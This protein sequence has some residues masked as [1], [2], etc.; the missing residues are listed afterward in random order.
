MIGKIER[1]PA[2]E[3]LQI[4]RSIKEPGPQIKEDPVTE[5]PSHESST[6]T[7]NARKNEMA[8]TSST[9]KSFLNSQVA[10]LSKSKAT[11]ATK[12][13]VPIADSSS[14]QTLKL[15]DKGPEVDRL[16][17]DLQMWQSK[18]GLEV[19][20]FPK[21]G[22]YNEEIERAVRQF[23]IANNMY[24]TGKA[25]SNTQNRLKLETDPN[26]RSLDNDVKQN[27]RSSMDIYAD[28]PAA[29]NNI[30]NLATDRQFAHLLSK[31]SQS[32]A[33]SGLLMHPEDKTHLKNV[34]DAVL[35]VAILEKEKSLDH[36]PE[37]TKRQVV[38]TLFKKTEDFPTP[39]Y[40]FRSS[41]ARERIIELA[42]NPQFG[43]L[44]ASQQRSLLD[45][46]SANHGD[47][48]SS[49]TAILDSPAYKK[50]DEK[51]KAHVVD[52]TSKNAML[53]VMQNLDPAKVGS[54][55]RRLES[56][57][58]L[59]L[60]PKFLEASEEDKWAQLKPFSNGV[61]DTKPEIDIL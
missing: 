10:A 25:D 3:Y 60:N 12:D 31:D 51:M 23:Q 28:Q 37:A 7:A 13:A 4:E 42:K 14:H 58:Q 41:E 52:L 2:T 15:G 6:Q 45:S 30:L 33:L 18:N 21:D 55:N 43:K 32:S 44:S 17:Y 54:Y 49:M 5:Y 50:M 59:M 24:A 48:A 61:P 56:L 8:I 53:P 40:F 57:E 22:V 9:Q 19:T 39:N 11:V 20:A 16:I 26:F 29:Q 46:V 47:A 36:L 38:S 34:Q 27:I 1:Q 35:D